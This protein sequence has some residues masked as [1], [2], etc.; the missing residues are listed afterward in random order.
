MGDKLELEGQW[1]G[2][3]KYGEDYPSE[4]TGEKVIFS[5]SVETIFNNKFSGKCV[6]IAGSHLIEEISQIEGFIENDFISFQKLYKGKY[7]FDDEGKSIEIEDQS[8]HELSYE[9]TYDF[10]SKSF[11]GEW[12]IWLND[13]LSGEFNYIL[14]G[15]GSWEMSKNAMK[16]GV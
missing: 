4:I 5:I 7:G 1:F 11:Y 12:E 15:A 2:F 9:G 16:Y 6:E 8:L 3:Y 10:A 14:I 13:R